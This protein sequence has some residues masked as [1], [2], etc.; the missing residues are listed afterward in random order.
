LNLGY[1]FGEISFGICS[2]ATSSAILV[3]DI[4]LMILF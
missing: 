1:W 2:S 3:S 4:L